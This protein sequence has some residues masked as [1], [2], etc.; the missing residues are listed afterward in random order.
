[1]NVVLTLSRNKRFAL[2]LLGVLALTSVVL[3]VL[4][5]KIM[6]EYNAFNA[7]GRDALLVG[8]LAKE[9]ASNAKRLEAVRLGMKHAWDGYTKYAWGHD[10]LKPLSRTG[11]DTMRLGAT[12]IGS[13][14]TLWIMGLK[15]E[16]N[17]AREWV[18][19]KFD[20]A[21]NTEVDF[22]EVSTQ[23]LGG[24]LSAYALSGDRVFLN[25]ALQ[26]G[27]KLSSAINEN[28][29]VPYT[30]VNLKT[31]ARRN[32]EHTQMKSVLA[33]VASAQLDFMY[34]STASGDRE[35]AQAAFNMFDNIFKLTSGMGGVVPA[36][37]DPATGR[38]NGGEFKFSRY[39]DSLL[40]LWAFLG[41]C[42]SPIAKVYRDH[43]DEAVES[44]HKYLLHKTL[45]S[46]LVTV[47]SYGEFYIKDSTMKLEA[48]FAG[49]MLALGASMCNSSAF[50]SKGRSAD[51]S[52][53]EQIA[54]T[55]NEM[56]IRS[57]THV[58]PESVVPNKKSDFVS[59]DSASKLRPEM[60]ETLFY[61]WRTTHDPKYR[62]WGWN[63]FLGIERYSRVSDSGY[64]GLKNAGRVSSE[65][66]DIQPP[67]FTAATLKYFYLLFSSDDVLPL[68]KYIFNVGAHPYLIQEP[69]IL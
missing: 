15:K 65:K 69:I 29:G 64:S 17:S 51:K 1:M 57:P 56:H 34:L 60:I 54:R 9:E 20:P 63:I 66:D 59:E 13:L 46:R 21:I 31:G 14:D 42:K 35:Y 12:L 55:C 2:R 10:E 53:A 19:N 67:W 23:V 11:H 28:S 36:L 6:R 37:V 27:E 68:D 61:L 5:S 58:A 26:L 16:F 30:L 24:L 49:G 32:T 8:T 40:K 43:Y 62:E 4:Q 18:R 47:G 45:P 48:C 39:I 33:E 22:A 25:K 50:P 3:L 38:C 41:N 7:N 52:L 44:G